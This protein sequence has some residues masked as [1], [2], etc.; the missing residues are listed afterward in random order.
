[1]CAFVVLGLIFPY[2]AKILTLG[3]ILCRVWRKTT[4]QSINQLWKSISIWHQLCQEYSGTFLTFS[5]RWH[6]FLQY[7]MTHITHSLVWT[8]ITPLHCAAINPN[9]KYLMKLLSILPE[10]GITDVNSHRPIHY[11]AACEGTG[12]LEYLLNRFLSCD[13]LFSHLILVM[14]FIFGSGP[15]L[16]VVVSVNQI[17][18][19]CTL[20]TLQ[21]IMHGMQCWPAVY[22]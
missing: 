16:S 6:G 19:V 10:Y 17:L 11:A 4:T 22:H 12:P 8:Q 13:V 2:Q 15:L 14:C 1:M 5:G 3:P 20:C 18:P 9:P 7:H 21:V